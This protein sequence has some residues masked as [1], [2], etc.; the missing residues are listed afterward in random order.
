V[1][2]G[3]SFANN[4]NGYLVDFRDEY[5]Q[6]ENQVALVGDP[7]IDTL[8]G[9]G[10]NYDDYY[11]RWYLDPAHEDFIT[12]GG[13]VSDTLSYYYRDFAGCPWFNTYPFN[14]YARPEP[15]F[16]VENL[17]ER[18]FTQITDVTHLDGDGVIDTW[19]WNFGD[20]NEI[21]LH[22][23]SADFIPP[24]THDGNTRGKFAIPEHRY[25]GPGEYDLT[26]RVVSDKGCENDT[27]KMV[28]IGGYPVVDFKFDSLLQNWEHILQ[29]QPPL[30]HLMK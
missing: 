10:L 28:V 9:P 15:D 16:T 17:C 7:G 21:I 24:N 26:M 1:Q 14:V 3:G 4:L 20:L 29:I 13:D 18:D 19:D 8:V 25:P 12:V 27:T 2:V 30:N 22:G 5:C 11:K 6:Y 23:D